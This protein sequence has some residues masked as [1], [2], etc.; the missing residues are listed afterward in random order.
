MW[1][2]PVGGL[3]RK[4]G[5]INELSVC[6]T[7]LPSYRHQ[8]AGTVYQSAFTVMMLQNRKLLHKVS[9]LIFSCGKKKDGPHP[10]GAGD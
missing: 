5:E 4:A 2:N 1:K 9:G 7:L 3:E 10:A 6:G 8:F